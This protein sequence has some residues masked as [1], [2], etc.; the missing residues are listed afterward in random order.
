MSIIE[1]RREYAALVDRVRAL[2]TE[3]GPE[4]DT[5][6]DTHDRELAARLNGFLLGHIDTE[7]L[8]GMV[9]DLTEDL[10]E[11]L[12]DDLEDLTAETA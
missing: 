9:L 12:I 6:M 2:L 8:F 7:E 1:N 5:L 4:A 10:I 11:D 3:V